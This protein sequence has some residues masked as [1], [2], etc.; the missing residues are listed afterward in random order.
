MDGSDV[1][2]PVRAALE[3]IASGKAT[4]AGLQN[5]MPG[6]AA[7]TRAPLFTVALR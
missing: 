7:P 1:P 2:P 5:A 6:R 3:R 4:L